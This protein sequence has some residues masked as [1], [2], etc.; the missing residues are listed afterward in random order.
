MLILSGGIAWELH[1]NKSCII[2]VTLALLQQNDIFY[3]QHSES[4]HLCIFRVLKN[5]PSS[6]PSY[7]L[8]YELLKVL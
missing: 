6:L 4:Q 5:F 1:A 2:N 8:T 3:T 7:R